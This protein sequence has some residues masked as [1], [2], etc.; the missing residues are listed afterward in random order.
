VLV[1]TRPVDFRKGMDGLAAA[2][3]RTRQAKLEDGP[4]V[5]I[6]STVMEAPI[7]A[8]PTVPPSSASTL[9]AIGRDH[10]GEL[11]GDQ[12]GRHKPRAAG[13]APGL[14][15]ALAAL[16]PQVPIHRCAVHK[17]RNL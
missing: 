8:P 6:G 3:S 17:H 16:W 13:E 12:S 14:E 15:A 1:A 10:R 4:M 11:G 5:R 9:R 2:I 7:H